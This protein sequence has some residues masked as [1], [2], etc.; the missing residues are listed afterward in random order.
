MKDNH[1]L[2]INQWA[3]DDRP[4]EK[5][6]KQGITALSNAELLAILIGSGNTEETAVGLMQRVLGSCDNN[7]NK[8]GKKS[9]DELCC[10]KGIGSAKAIAI[11][12]AMELG[13]RR[14]LEEATERKT[15]RC[16]KD[17]Y[18]LFHPLLCDLPTE[19][20]WI[21]LLNQ[22]CTVIEQIKISSGGITETS[23]DIRTI[24]REALI[25]RATNLAL[26]HNHPSGN[27]SPSI[28][29]E[30]L[31]NKVQQASKLM[32]ITLIDHLIVCD[33]SYFSFADEGKL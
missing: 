25:H 22:A 16:S 30:R 32:N 19:E 33:G 3:E 20:F 26:C 11:E 8:L 14:K 17:I 18:L 15:I 5:M 4:R 1:K 29:D 23:A 21:L 24:L 6:Q 10:F 31:T 28:D 2:N 12:A 27:T 13:K 9:I 7:L